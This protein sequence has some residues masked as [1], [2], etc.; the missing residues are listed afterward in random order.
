MNH[1]PA[2]FGNEGSSPAN[3]LKGLKVESTL[4]I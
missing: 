2:N 1:Q 3:L 4:K